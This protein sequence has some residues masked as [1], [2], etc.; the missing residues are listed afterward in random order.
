M[1]TLKLSDGVTLSYHDSG[2]ATP[3]LFLHSFGHNKNLWF[4]Q[5]TH[6]L[7]RGF[8][9]LAPDMPGHGESSYDPARHEVDQMAQWYIE[10]LESLDI[11]KA[12]VA[13][14]SMG[15]YI[16][17]RMWARQRDLIAAMVLSNTKAEKDSEE[18]VARRRAQ[19]A[20]IHKNGLEHFVTTGAPK[21]LSPVTLERRPW[22]LD[23]IKLLNYTVPAEVNAATLE[24]MARKQD[25][26]KV[27]PTIDV[28]VLVIAGSDDI[29][30]PKDS[31]GNLHRGIR[32]SRFHEI[33]GTGHVSSLEAPTEY[34]RAMEEFL[35][36]AGLM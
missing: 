5:L 27:L 3:I 17:L 16:A 21:R 8:R 1:A 29:F 26:T 18:I 7:E 19:I 23:T 13:G 12:I 10:L 6:F 14:I 11:G 36:A 4:P 32:G 25:D 31:P 2:S 9:V 34:N 33:A 30:I 35:R 22:V 20:N 28:P 15:G 24:A